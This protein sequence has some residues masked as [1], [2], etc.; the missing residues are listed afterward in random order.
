MQ[1]NKNSIFDCSL[2]CRHI[3]KPGAIK[4]RILIRLQLLLLA[5]GFT[6][7]IINMIRVSHVFSFQWLTHVIINRIRVS[8]VY[9]FQWF[10]PVIINRIRVSHVIS[11]E[12]RILLIIT[13]VNH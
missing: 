7:V 6:P 11:L 13:G 1:S 10:T 8:H 12:T 5:P 2:L 4:D 3:P 9:I